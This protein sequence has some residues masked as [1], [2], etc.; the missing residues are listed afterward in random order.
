MCVVHKNV[1]PTLSFLRFS[2][3]AVSTMLAGN[4]GS[5]CKRFQ[6][7][8]AFT[9]C[10]LVHTYIVLCYYTLAS[11]LF[12]ANTSTHFRSIVSICGLNFVFI[13][14]CKHRMCYRIRVTSVITS[15]ASGFVV[16]IWELNL[17]FRSND[18]LISNSRLGF[19]NETEKINRQIVLRAQLINCQ[20]LFQ[21]YD[22]VNTL[23]T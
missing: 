21:S 17:A 20:M 11:V 1:P 6:S 16:K 22:S 10:P 3:P 8:I 23:D 15:T 4:P 12:F 14:S 2:P 19:I 18:R 7:I 13:Q 9:L 5:N